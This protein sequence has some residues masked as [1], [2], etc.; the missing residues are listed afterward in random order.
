MDPT[1]RQAR[2]V[3]RALIPMDSERLHRMARA[4]SLSHKGS[5]KVSTALL[6]MPRDNPLDSR[7]RPSNSCMS[8]ASKVEPSTSVSAHKMKSSSRL[9]QQCLG[10]FMYRLASIRHRSSNCS[11]SRDLDLSFP[12][13]IL[14]S[15]VQRVKTT[16]GPLRQ[17]AHSLRF[18]TFVPRSMGGSSRRISSS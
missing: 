8:R 6:G 9:I 11:R 16:L 2:T 15:S 4:I 10:P 5:F 7:E 3:A 13:A 17:T 1:G 12:R 14:S 18:K